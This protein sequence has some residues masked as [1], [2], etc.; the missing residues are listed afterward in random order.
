MIQELNMHWMQIY[1]AIGVIVALTVI[2]FFIK[3]FRKIAKEKED[4]D[5]KINLPD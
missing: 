2:F 5:G 1:Y 4:Y 3:E